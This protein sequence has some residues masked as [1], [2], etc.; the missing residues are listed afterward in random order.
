MARF[1]ANRMGDFE[2]DVK[3]GLRPRLGDVSARDTV[4]TPAVCSF[5]RLKTGWRLAPRFLS[6]RFVQRW[7]YLLHLKSCSRAFTGTRYVGFCNSLD[8]IR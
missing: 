1:V 6:M 8:K 4:Y 7:I 2:I 5:I 3:A